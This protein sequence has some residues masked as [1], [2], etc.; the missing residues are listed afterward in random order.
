VSASGGGGAERLTAALAPGQRAWIHARDVD[1]GREVGLDADARV[2]ISSIAKLALLT[3]LH[4][5]ADAGALDLAAPRTV[6]VEGRTL[7]FTGLS[8]FSDPATLSLRDLALLMITVSDNAAADALFD[9]VDL[10]CVNREMAALGLP[11]IAL[12]QTLRDL[13]AMLREDTG[14]AGPADAAAHLDDPARLRV[15][16]PD[17]ASSASPRDLTALLAAIWRDEAASPEAC[18]EMR[19]VLGLQVWPHRLASG[20]PSD[21]VRV[22]GKTATLPTMRHEV[23]VVEYPDGGRYAVA[24]LTQTGSPAPTQP[25]ADAAIGAAGRT[26]VELL[27]EGVSASSWSSSSSPSSSPAP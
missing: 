2:P 14:A 1:G 5:R 22:S 3:A 7:G 11:G 17:Q 24:I 20:F 18:A 21:D 9:V 10:D 13:F 27:R 23:G 26:A 16:D 12:R 15:L 4:R 25:R 6:P 8:V 19:R